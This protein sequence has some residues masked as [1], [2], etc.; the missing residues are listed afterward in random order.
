MTD[1]YLFNAS[2]DAPTIGGDA[3]NYASA[4]VRKL[5]VSA[6]LI[7]SELIEQVAF[8]PYMEL[9]AKRMTDRSL[10]SMDYLYD[11]G[12]GERSTTGYL[13]DGFYASL[14]SYYQTLPL[15]QDNPYLRDAVLQGLITSTSAAMAHCYVR[16]GSHEKGCALMTIISAP[17]A[18]GK[19]S[20]TDT[21]Q[22]LKLIDSSLR[23]SREE[24]NKAYR[25]ECR[26]Y[27]IVLGKIKKDRNLS[28]EER[29][30]AIAALD[31]PQAP[32][33][34]MIM[35]ASDITKARFINDL[36]TNGIYPSLMYDTELSNMLSSNKADYGDQLLLLLKIAEEETIHKSIKQDGE[37]HFVEHPRMS[38]LT[39][40]V[41]E[42]VKLFAQTFSTGMG[43]RLTLID[44]PYDSTFRPDLDDT[45]Y[46]RQRQQVE[47][48]QNGLKGM[49]DEL[50]HVG[51]TGT[52]YILTLTDRQRQQIAQFFSTMTYTMEARYGSPEV[53]SVV[54]R[55]QLDMKR[56]LMQISL[57]RRYD[58][59][60]SWA[61]A[62]SK[63]YVTPTDRDLGLTLYYTHH[64]IGKCVDVYR[65]HGMINTVDV[66]EKTDS[67]PTR[68]EVFRTMPREFTRAELNHLVCDTHHFCKKTVQR[69]LEA[70][71][72]AGLIVATRKDEYRKCSK[73][74]RK[75]LSK[76][77]AKKTKRT[78]NQQ[79][80]TKSMSTTC[81][82]DCVVTA[83]LTTGNQN[84]DS[85]VNY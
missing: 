72:K 7:K 75:K 19:S 34:E 61:E 57:M 63:P 13:P 52:N 68:D 53:K 10:S 36:D 64:L 58:E 27:E 44:L 70:W 17:P 11:E 85:N 74:E 38:L 60:G 25:N 24:R 29:R 37:E 18:Q 33:C 9:K 48:L 66:E 39:T 73:E 46:Q 45:T 83:V 12:T 69:Y 14:P 26:L 30:Q 50:R 67:R 21:T 79:I 47:M 78:I 15:V 51:D 77:S 5:Q 4:S 84:T 54:L 22:V 43:S 82:K 6:E 71:T 35:L 65:H 80:K 41:P 31:E 76:K 56:I 16:Q 59:C 81:H 55:K 42:Q 3:S 28:D 8:T 32:K 40:C 23:Q 20:V 1:N 62:L 49:Y 2:T